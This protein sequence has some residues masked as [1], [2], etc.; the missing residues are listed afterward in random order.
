LLNQPK[1]ARPAF[2]GSSRVIV[3]RTIQGAPKGWRI[4]VATVIDGF[5]LTAQ[6]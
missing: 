1:H 5:A 3:S 2:T 6:A 4:E